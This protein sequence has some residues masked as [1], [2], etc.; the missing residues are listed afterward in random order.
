VEV[1]AGV[2]SPEEEPLI[3]SGKHHNRQMPLEEAITAIRA[4]GLAIIGSFILGLD[5]ERPGAGDRII[6][7]IER[8]AIPLAM[9][10]LLQP[11]PRT[12][13]W[14]RLRKEGRLL[15]K[16]IK[17]VKEFDSIGGRPLFLPNRPWEQIMDEYYRVWDTIYEPG[18]FLDR[19]YRFFLGMRPTR[20][21]IARRQGKSLPPPLVPSVKKPFPH[22]LRDVLIFLRMSWKLGVVS[23]TRWQFW[24]QLLGMARKNPSRLVGYLVCCAHGE[25]IFDLRDLL[26]QRRLVLQKTE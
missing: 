23:G 6:S 16:D 11:P 1:F 3:R 22:Q 2:E 8:T 17:E 15:E 9:V 12:R 4:N 24:R 26:R 18:R 25:D 7:F 19:A 13:L 10:N 20:A 21:E 14:Q 5:G